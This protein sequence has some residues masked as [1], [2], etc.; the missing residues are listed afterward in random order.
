LFNEN[1][2]EKGVKVFFFIET[3]QEDKQMTDKRE[4]KR[5]GRCQWGKKRIRTLFLPSAESWLNNKIEDTILE[6]Q[7]F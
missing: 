2:D 4:N 5:L 1:N 7:G 6:G 3:K